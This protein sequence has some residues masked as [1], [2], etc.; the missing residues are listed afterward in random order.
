MATRVPWLFPTSVFLSLHSPV[1]MGDRCHTYAVGGLVACHRQVAL[2]VS[3][4]STE[5]SRSVVGSQGL[6]RGSTLETD[7]PCSVV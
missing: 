6:M 1:S 7:H 3:G 2:P 5:V 4:M